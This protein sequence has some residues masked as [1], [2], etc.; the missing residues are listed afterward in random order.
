M[1]GNQTSA[2][3]D[4]DELVEKL[5]ED[6]GVAMTLIMALKKKME[7]IHDSIA[8]RTEV[9]ELEGSM[10]RKV[11]DVLKVAKKNVSV[12]KVSEYRIVEG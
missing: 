9:A 6:L 4:R 8:T 5:K 2:N 11:K 10:K 7:D 1:G 12:E 3:D